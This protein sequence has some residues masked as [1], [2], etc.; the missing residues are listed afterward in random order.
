MNVNL[1]SLTKSLVLAQGHI[2]FVS[3]VLSCSDFQK[4]TG[5]FAILTES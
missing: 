3:L 1:I 2:V 5:L 4:I